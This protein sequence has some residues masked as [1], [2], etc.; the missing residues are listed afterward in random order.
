MIDEISLLVRIRWDPIQYLG[1]NVSSSCCLFFPPSPLPLKPCD[2][3]PHFFLKYQIFLLPSHHTCPGFC[4]L[5]AHRFIEFRFCAYTGG[6]GGRASQ[7]IADWVSG[8]IGV[9]IYSVWHMYLLCTWP[10]S[11][12]QT[13]Y[14]ICPLPLWRCPCLQLKYISKDTMYELQ[15]YRESLNMPCLGD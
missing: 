3:S 6:R 14:S 9:C 11:G 8:G 4:P 13:P 5:H 7:C 15:W 12:A 2:D 1:P 10:C